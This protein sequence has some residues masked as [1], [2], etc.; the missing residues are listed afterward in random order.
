MRMSEPIKPDTSLDETYSSAWSDHGKCVGTDHDSP[1]S[2]ALFLA[3]HPDASP[4]ERLDVLLTDQ[5]L[6]WR[7]GCPKR[8]GDYV[9]EHP[10]S[11]GDP[12]AILRLIQGEFL[13]LLESD[14]AADPAV[15]MRMF[16]EL[17][18]EIGSQCEVD[19]WLTIPFEATPSLPGTADFPATDSEG[20][21]T[22][23]EPN[24]VAG[25]SPGRTQEP[26][27]EHY[28][29]LREADFK[30][31]RLLGSGGMGEVYEAIQKS[32][33]KHVALKLIKRDAL[34]SPSRV[35]RFFAEARALARLRHPHIVGVHGI[36][37]MTD[38]RYFLVMDLIAGGTTLAP[39]SKTG[40]VSCESAAALVG[41]VAE[42]IA[43]AH[44]RGVIHRDLKPSNV[45]IDAEG[46][47]HVTDFGLAKIFDSTD[48][49]QPQTTA[50]TV[51]GTP[52]Y[53]T[54][55]Q[56]DPARGPI[57]PRT[58][59]YAL[60]GLLY[61]LL[62]G[63]P[64]IQGESLTAVLAQVVSPAPVRAPRELR[65]DI[66]PALER[67]CRTCLEKDADNRYASAGAV[68]AALNSWLSSP[69][70]EP[71]QA[72]TD[73]ERKG[74]D[75]DVGLGM[76]NDAVSPGETL[77]RP[78]S[79]PDTSRDIRDRAYWPTDRSLKEKRRGSPPDDWATK[80]A[81]AA[82]SHR[83]VLLAG[84]SVVS[85]LLVCF[86]V[87]GHTFKL[88]ARVPIDTLNPA[89]KP[90][91]AS[92]PDQTQSI[93]SGS[94]PIL[95][96]ADRGRSLGPVPSL[97]SDGASIAIRASKEIIDQ[98]GPGSGSIAI[99]L[100][101]SGSMLEPKIAPKFPQAKSALVQVLS[102]VPP[103][104]VVSLWIFSQLPDKFRGPDGTFAVPP[105][106]QQEAAQLVLEPE[107]T[108]ESIRPPTPW[109][110]S[111][112]YRLVRKL[113]E[114]FPWFETPLVQAML[115]AA[116]TD[117]KSASGLRTMLVLTDGADTRLDK[118]VAINP[119]KLP[120]ADFV[121]ENF[122]SLGIAINMVFFTLEG[123]PKAVETA[124]TSFAQALKR[125][126]PPGSFVTADSLGEMKQALK[127]GIEQKLTCQILKAHGI[128]V[129]HE[130]LEV[131][132]PGELE[133]W[134]QR[135]APGIYTLRFRTNKVYD[136]EI[137]LRKFDRLIVNLVVG[138]DGGIVFKPMSAKDEN[139]RPSLVLMSD[140]TQPDLVPFG[141][142]PL[143]TIP[144]RQKYF[145]SVRNPSQVDHDV[146]VEIVAGSNVIATSGNKPLPA[147]LLRETPVP[148]FV[149]KVGAQ[150]LKDTDPLPEAPTG[151]KLRLRNAT[152]Q[153]VFDE[154]PLEPVIATPLEYLEVRPPPT[155]KPAR[156]GEPSL[157]E[158]SLRSLPQ[159]L[160]PASKIKLTIPPNKDLFSDLL[161][162]QGTQEG[163]LEPGGKVLKLNAKGIKLDPSASTEDGLFY[164]TIDGLERVLWY[165]TQFVAEGVTRIATRH[166]EPR[167]R[168]EATRVV[169]KDQPAKLVVA[170][171]V[172]N[173]PANAFLD[174]H[175]VQAMGGESTDDWTRF[176]E[177]AKLQ[178]IGFDHAGPDGALQFEASVGDWTREFPTRGLRGP[179]KLRANLFDPRSRKVFDTWETDLVLDDVPPNNAIIETAARVP[180]VT[181]HLLV[182]ATVT[183]PASG[184]AEVEFIVGLKR[185]FAK[186]DVVAKAVKGKRTGS[187]DSTWE[188]I[189]PLSKDATGKIVVTAR[190][191]SGVGLTTLVSADVEIGPV[192]SPENA[193]AA[194]PEP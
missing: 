32:L 161:E 67:I 147:P 55:E 167:V 91:S 134:S 173:A 33:R 64:P 110:N 16:P 66:P 5:L 125:L 115:K 191:T 4:A 6:R 104:T 178:H 99:V 39:L 182:K 45:L 114:I 143:R 14:Q 34:D 141:R 108:I 29:P 82:R 107:R 174:F 62:T 151:L 23:A 111:Q 126:D 183:P 31:T 131:T 165:K 44:S 73:N 139:L 38:G 13:A 74:D 50:D 1:P 90:N 156:P 11:T 42:A 22:A 9:A 77:A 27:T 186:P 170:F 3:S 95:E 157:L 124:R 177:I 119:K 10:T 98:F 176:R 106:L 185:D 54:P 78:D 179:M 61:V 150:A 83:R 43:H 20:D 105:G 96:F 92:V 76:W 175:L 35:R 17:S 65:A 127:L 93:E 71:D 146:I 136:Q 158:V 112:I 159:M 155:F 169:K 49:D 7:R 48:P 168:F 116:K 28:A 37:R 53:M 69:H 57:T 109:N 100:D 142:L 87:V 118:N 63:K 162:S 81:A 171:T 52:H 85:L 194:K 187:D 138:T 47:P 129:D 120:I 128:P 117:L 30:R 132:A 15:Y 70:A 140:S 56:A 166:D 75:P 72:E 59:V 18:Q 2:A 135:L 148:A 19:R 152:D 181:T 149:S 94:R 160:G 36:G 133:R 123:D 190:F 144:H 192:P 102:Q 122:R 80:W 193:A 184:I 86:L 97:S 84:A 189:L 163:V 154:Q 21:A 46:N 26:P 41:S 40:T 58:D 24:Y 8:V 25:R 88:G 172:D 153:K 180:Q 89:R 103:G 79:L 164:L 101:C 12:E 113:D 145:V 121:T 188:G 130:P 68:A 51:L 60:G 137:D